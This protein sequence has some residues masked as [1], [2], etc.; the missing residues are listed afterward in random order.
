[1]HATI[2]SLSSDFPIT[3]VVE[4]VLKFTAIICSFE[5]IQ[6]V[7]DNY[8][9]VPIGSPRVFKTEIDKSYQLFPPFILRMCTPYIRDKA[10]LSQF[11]N[12]FTYHFESMTSPHLFMQV[13]YFQGISAIK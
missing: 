3:N 5:S 4:L 10:E 2:V 12:D 8:L 6:L 9:L 11:D 7:V 1:M 13:D